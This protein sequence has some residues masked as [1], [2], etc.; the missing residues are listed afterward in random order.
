M[1]VKE[2]IKDYRKGKKVGNIVD[3]VFISGYWYIYS[4][5][6]PHATKK[7]YV[8]EHR[9]IAEKTIGRFFKRWW[10]CASHKRKQIR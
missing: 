10:G 7:G 4:P 8:A 6:H 5:Y 3:K 9:L 2:L 1:T